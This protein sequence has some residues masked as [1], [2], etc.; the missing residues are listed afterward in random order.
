MY[1]YPSTPERNFKARNAKIEEFYQN[2]GGCNQISTIL[3][4]L[5]PC[6]VVN[7]SLWV[8]FEVD[9]P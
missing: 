9:F 3:G 1:S 6:F 7:V 4:K 5:E 2:L 8:D